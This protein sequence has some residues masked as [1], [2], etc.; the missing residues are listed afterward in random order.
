MPDNHP[1]RFKIPHL[2]TG[3]SNMIKVLCIDDDVDQLHLTKSFLEKK[4]GIEVV[5]L[6]NP[7]EALDL[8]D[9][10]VF[11]AIISD[12]QMPEMDGLELLRSLRERGNEV[13]FIIFTGKGRE[14]VAVHAYDGGADGY[15]QKGTDIRSM[16]TELASRL[17]SGVERRRAMK[18][19]HDS[20]KMF[21]LIT[22][23]VRDTVWMMNTEQKIT[24][25]SPSVIKQSGYSLQELN[26]K[27]VNEHLTTSSFEKLAGEVYRYLVADDPA[28]LNQTI[29]INEELEYRRKDGSIYCADTIITSIRDDK[30]VLQGFLGVGRDI[31]DKKVVEREKEERQRKL[32]SLYSAG[33]T[34]MG[35]AKNRL[36]QEVN[37]QFLE[38]TGYS[39]EE[40]VGKGTRILYT[41]DAEYQRVGRVKY[42]D[43]RK[44]GTGT[45]E[46]QWV[47]KDGRVIDVL[48]SS[49]GIKPFSEEEGVSFIAIDISDRVILTERLKQDQMDILKALQDLDQFFSLNLD[50]FSI[51]DMDGTIVR[52]NLEWERTLGYKLQDIVG[53]KFLD[54]IHPDDMPLTLNA[55]AALN[56]GKD[57]I[58]SVNRVRRKDG[59]YRYLEL[60]ASPYDGGVIYAAA[61]DITDRIMLEKSLRLANIRLNLLTQ[62][63]R[64]DLRNQL[65]ILMGQVDMISGIKQED[66]PDHKRKMEQRG[67]AMSRVIDSTRDYQD[68]GAKEPQWLSWRSLMRKAQLDLHA[69]DME[70]VCAGKDYEIFADPLLEKV[71]YN[72]LDNANR[73]AGPK[74]NVVV[75][76]FTDDD[77]LH[78][79]VQDDGP[80]ISPKDRER[81]FEPG[82]GRGHGLGLFLSREIL[83]IT[84]LDIRESGGK[85][86]GARF[87]ITV[88][89]GQFRPI[90][91]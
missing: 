40:I 22:D 39:R 64:H 79:I 36:Y 83:S 68:L 80:G 54:F 13:V 52:I 38:M 90:S 86:G 70:L 45:V 81:L 30:G 72:L 89:S 60:R 35:F 19:L 41:D 44:N 56:E 47:R 24:W 4:G 31:T 18:D 91:S 71:F 7:V 59:Q 28:N 69:E 85:A 9:R 42:E 46:T 77:S 67:N 37:D 8:L 73:Y 74:A 34:G 17:I 5:V 11:D 3:P 82:Q 88:P 58:N 15:V 14:D 75:E 16:F 51:I 29:S 84:D 76:V 55:L 61:R 78:L 6:S 62:I 53:R 43:V 12:Y 63:T 87:E 26:E 20:E 25:I 57:V 10:E 23:N 66:M 48:L 32:D 21:R 65:F 49:S 33:P 50:L 27:S 2:S 1:I